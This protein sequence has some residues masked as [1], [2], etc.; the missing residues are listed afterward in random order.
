MVD[1]CVNCEQLPVEGRIFLLSRLKFF[2]EETQWLARA[3][4]RQVLL[5]RAP[6][7]GG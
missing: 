7:V 3:L 6:N 5:Q 1:A 4:P 2:G